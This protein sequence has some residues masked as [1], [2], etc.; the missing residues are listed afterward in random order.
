MYRHSSCVNAD[1][2]LD[3]TEIFPNLPVIVGVHSANY[4]PQDP[5][6]LR[7]TPKILDRTKEALRELIHHDFAGR[8][9]LGAKLLIGL[10]RARPYPESTIGPV[11][12]VVLDV[13]F[14]LRLLRAKLL[15]YTICRFGICFWM[16]WTEGAYPVSVFYP[17][18]VS[19]AFKD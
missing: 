14:H 10:L 5:A 7:A 19:S 13:L 16:C 1:S 9:C 15:Y 4:V 8:W 6:A 3:G 17:K 18:Y 12:V 2:S 11:E